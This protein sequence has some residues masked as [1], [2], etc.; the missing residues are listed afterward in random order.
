MGESARK[1][2]K[3]PAGAI[4]KRAAPLEHTASSL[5]AYQ[6]LQALW[7]TTQQATIRRALEETARAAYWPGPSEAVPSSHPY[8]GNRNHSCEE[9]ERS[10]E[11]GSDAHP[12]TSEDGR[13][14]SD[15]SDGSG[16]A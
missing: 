16:S 8:S 11:S 13:N 1:R 7:G 15:W 5:G 4:V 14:P 12:A 3:E 6:Y 10:E 2:S 9:S